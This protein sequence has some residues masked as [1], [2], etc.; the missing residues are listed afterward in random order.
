MIDPLGP[1]CLAGASLIASGEVHH[2]Y[3]RH[4]HPD[5]KVT[6]ELYS[7]ARSSCWLL[8]GGM[9]A[10]GLVL[11]LNLP[12]V[13]ALACGDLMT[14]VL[15]SMLGALTSRAEA[16]CALYS[17]SCQYYAYSALQ[18]L[19][20]LSGI[21][22]IALRFE[23]ISVHTIR[24]SECLLYL[25]GFGGRAV[26]LFRHLEVFVVDPLRQSRVRTVW[27]SLATLCTLLGAVGIF[28]L[29][30]TQMP[31]ADWGTTLCHWAAAL[32][33]QQAVTPLHRKPPTLAPKVVT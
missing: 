13:W 5:R 30:Q 31:G 11:V 9:L 27:Q 8:A 24:G 10:R 4:H 26:Y 23:G 17:P 7:F 21:A 19:L 3:V 25:L 33:L 14:T 1:V 20:W 32:Y 16:G 2:L 28:Q 12:L 29:A 6:S 18:A 15:L 22:V